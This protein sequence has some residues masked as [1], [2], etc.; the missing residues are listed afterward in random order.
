MKNSNS[1]FW[2]KIWESHMKQKFARLLIQ[3]LELDLS[4]LIQSCDI[5]DIGFVIVIQ[6]KAHIKLQIPICE[7]LTF[8]KSQTRP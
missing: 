4:V 6:L 8:S 2:V 1:Q 5:H 7:Y 3:T